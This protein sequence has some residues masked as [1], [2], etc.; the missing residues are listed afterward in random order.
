MFEGQGELIGDDRGLFSVA[1]RIRQ[2]SLESETGRVLFREAFGHE[3]WLFGVSVRAGGH[4][5][6]RGRD[7]C[8]MP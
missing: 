3:G 4:R 5:H 2:I 6:Y 8:A 7:E 1:V